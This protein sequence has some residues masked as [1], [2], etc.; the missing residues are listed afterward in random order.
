MLNF[1]GFWGAKPHTTLGVAPAPH[2]LSGW[3]LDPYLILETPPSSRLGPARLIFKIKYPF[4]LHFVYFIT[5][6]ISQTEMWQNRL[7]TPFVRTGIRDLKISFNNFNERTVLGACR[8]QE[9]GSGTNKSAQALTRR[10]RKKTAP[11]PALS[12]GSNH[13]QGKKLV[14]VSEG[15]GRPAI[16]VTV[17]W[18]FFDELDQLMAKYIMKDWNKTQNNLYYYFKFQCQSDTN[19]A[20]SFILFHRVP[21]TM[22]AFYVR[23]P[24]F[25]QSLP[26][27]S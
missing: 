24:H 17:R 20:A 19:L 11:H 25:A 16:V 10:D 4:K 13:T 7:Q 21:V 27:K 22:S 8:T 3:P 5:V 26:G 14:K 12:R 23:S 1:L 9:G 18:Q 6:P 2:Q 15:S